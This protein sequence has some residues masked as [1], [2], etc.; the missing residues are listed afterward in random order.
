MNLPIDRSSTAGLILAGIFGLIFGVLLDRGNVNRYDVIVNFF[1]LKNFRVLKIMLTAI[2]VGGIGVLILNAADLATFH[3]KD[4][5]IGGILLGGL[6]FGVGMALL[7]YCPG[8]GIAAMATGSI[9]G[10]VGSLGMLAGAG[11]YGITYPWWKENVISIGDYGK[12]TLADSGLP[13]WGWWVIIVIAALFI[14]RG[15]IKRI[16]K[17]E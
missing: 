16:E 8:T 7:G 3:I 13:A 1:R 2:V 12:V 10:W 9:H 6:I 17:S 4:L 14:L 11:F 5:S 15:P